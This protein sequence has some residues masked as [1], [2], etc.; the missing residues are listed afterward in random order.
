MSSNEESGI[1]QEVDRSELTDA[2]SSSRIVFEE[3]LLVFIL[4]MVSEEDEE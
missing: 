4:Q 2:A 1:K 3:A